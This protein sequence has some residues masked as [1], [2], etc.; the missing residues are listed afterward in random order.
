MKDSSTEENI[1]KAA[2]SVF[3]KKGMAGARMQE[4]AD[5]AKINKAMLHYYYRNKQQLFEAVFMLAFQKFAPHVNGIFNSEASVFEKIKGFADSYI[6][7]VIENPYL[8]TF[9]IQEININPEFAETFFTA[10]SAPDP[11]L[12]EK[13]IAEEIEKGILRPVDPKQLLLNLFSL[14]AFPFVGSG[15]IKGI[16]KLDKESFNTMMEERKKL[17]PQLIIN[18]I[19]T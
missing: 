9:L 12:F 14:C 5:E 3:Q 13:Q 16:L 7:F 17:V 6:S 15:L 11:A 18:S 8:P 10:N 2:T 19:K 1:L 4:I